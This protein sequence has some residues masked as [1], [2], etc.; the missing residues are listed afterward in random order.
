MVL[1]PS[2]ATAGS[3]EARRA[4]DQYGAR[5][6]LDLRGKP[7]RLCATGAHAVLAHCTR[8]RQN[9]PFVFQQQFLIRAW[10]RS[11]SRAQLHPMNRYLNT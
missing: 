9:P 5:A 8:A 3:S 7:R 2:A 11:T 6:H 10:R 1:E 4:P